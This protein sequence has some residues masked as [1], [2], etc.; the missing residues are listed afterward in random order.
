MYLEFYGFREKPFNLTPDPRFVFLSKIHR[1]AFA[2]LLYGIDNRAGFIALTGEVGAGKTTV[3]RALLSNLNSDRHRSA[4]IFNPTLSPS[5][6]VQ[7]ISRE[8]GITTPVSPDASILGV[9]NSFLLQQN[10]EGRTVVLV[11]DEAQ[12]LEAPVLEQIRLISNLE[13]DRDK[14]I[15]IVLSGQPEFLQI[16]NKNEMRQLNQR[17]TVR[18]HLQPMDF[19]DT[20]AYINHRIRVAGRRGNVIFSRGAQKRIFKYSRGFPRLINAACDRALLAGYTKDEARITSKIAKAGIDDLCRNAGEVSMKRR[21]FL[22]PTL[23]MLAA[24]LA[25]GLYFTG[26][27]FL[28]PFKTAQQL[29]ATP[30]ETE[31]N[32][33]L[34]GEDVPAALANELGKISE[35]ESA[36]KAFNVLAGLWKVSPL[37]ESVNLKLANGMERAAQERELRLYWF[38]GNLGALLRFDYPA[39]LELRLNGIS[40]KRF[41]SLVGIENER[42]LLDSPLSGMKS[43]TFKE[44]EQHWTGQGFLLWKDSLNLLTRA[45]PGSWGGSVKQ[46]QSLLYEAGTYRRPLTGVYDDGTLSAVKEFQA[47]RGILQD[48]IAGSQTLMFLYGSGDRFRTPK[49]TAEKK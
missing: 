27:D 16:L 9:L 19:E 41:V 31:G 45:L 10:A 21:F 26:F 17:I 43:L 38:S 25:G 30:E 23:V 2:H 20:V 48:G 37:S 22:V 35:E 3:L 33:A 24:L 4:L 6:L 47:S 49:L 11:I 29:E 5:A 1:E 46:L 40:G 14:L 7:N 44:L 42:L 15:Q 13:T 28:E 18:A 34:T 39:A 32:P 36:S 8:F 12:D